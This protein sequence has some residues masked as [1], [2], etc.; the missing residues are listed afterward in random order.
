MITL[1]FGLASLS[2]SEKAFKLSGGAKEWL[3]IALAIF[4]AAAALALATNAPLPYK[5][6]K[7]EALKRRLKEEPIR[8]EE[9]AIRDIAL[10]QANMLRSAKT[11]N[12]IKGWL[13]IAAMAC[14]V[15]AIGFVGAAIYEVIHP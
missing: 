8:D 5:G 12:A 7:A 14:E 6:P 4:I 10:T 1:L 11:M 13:L 2:V 9:A 15:V 3:E